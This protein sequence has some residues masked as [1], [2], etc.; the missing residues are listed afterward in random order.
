MIMRVMLP[1]R[2]M[3][4][5]QYERDDHAKRK[6]WQGPDRAIIAHMRHEWAG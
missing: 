5:N 6:G 3:A 2:N 1:M 4:G